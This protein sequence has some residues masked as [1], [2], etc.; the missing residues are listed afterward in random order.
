MNSVIH[1]EEVFVVSY[2]V[3]VIGGI[4][5][6]APF[7]NPTTYS[8]NQFFYRTQLLLSEHVF[9]GIYVFV[10]LLILIYNLTKRHQN[11]VIFLIKVNPV[12]IFNHRSIISCHT[13]KKN[14]W[15]LCITQISSK[16]LSA[17]MTA[18]FDNA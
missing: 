6:S 4:P 5:S 18:L 13:C 15:F 14:N 10:V 17:T 1:P 16:L 2:L 3:N 12:Q 7:L 11:G 9:S 8:F